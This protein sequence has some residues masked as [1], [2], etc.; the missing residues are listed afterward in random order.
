MT[1]G[2]MANMTKG[3][4]ANMTKGDLTKITYIFQIF[5]EIDVKNVTCL[6]D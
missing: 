4:L 3:D 2:E 6:T 1:I 5:C